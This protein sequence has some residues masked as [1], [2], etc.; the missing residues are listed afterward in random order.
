MTSS[1][2]NL[3]PARSATPRAGSWTAS[4]PS[5]ARR[6]GHRQARAP[7][8]ASRAPSR[9]PG[10]RRRT[11]RWPCTST[12]TRLPSSPPG[13]TTS[14]PWRPDKSSRSW[15]RR[16][17]RPRDQPPDASPPSGGQRGLGALAD[18]RL[19]AGRGQVGVD[20]RRHVIAG[21]DDLAL[22]QPDHAVT[23]LLDLRHA[24]RD[25]EDGAGL[26][27]EFL[28][29]LAAPDAELRVPGDQCLV[30]E[31]HLVAA[32]GGDGEAQPRAHRSE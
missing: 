16:L 17:H 12:P 7:A 3:P 22:F 23:G 29:P 10:S 21:P 1:S 25:D 14:T 27:P 26:R 13:W 19:A 18:E 32:G 2:A 15:P 4:S 30:D 8:S 5:R 20:D 6:T 24:V 11:T 9:P 31:Q 28:D